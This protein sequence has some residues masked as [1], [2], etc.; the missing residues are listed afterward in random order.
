MARLYAYI[1]SLVP[2]STGR[3]QG[4]AMTEYALILGV[5]SIGLIV[6]LTAL[7]DSIADFFGGASSTL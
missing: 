5:L 6:S 3:E 1:T 4:Q 7:R 2:S